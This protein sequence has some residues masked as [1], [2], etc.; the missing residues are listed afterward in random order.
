MAD[1]SSQSSEQLRR[2]ME[3][4]PCYKEGQMSMKCLEENG[5]VRDRC[6]LHFEN[7]KVGSRLQC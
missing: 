2:H 5:Y 1:L 4:D 6:L 7:Y 3:L